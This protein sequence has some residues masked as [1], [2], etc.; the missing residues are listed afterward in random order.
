MPVVWLLSALSWIA[1]RVCVPWVR[2]G[3]ACLC[4]CR[5]RSVHTLLCGGGGGVVVAHTGGMLAH[6]ACVIECR[7]LP[8]LASA[9]AEVMRLVQTCRAW[10]NC[11][12]HGVDICLSVSSHSC[13]LQP[14]HA[15]H[16]PLCAP[17]GQT[18]GDQQA[19]LS[20]KPLA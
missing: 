8:S 4:Q 9:G 16:Y 15:Y 10:F 17:W 3:F 2:I 20:V 18:A 13:V 12:R 7:R 1:I 11:L 5:L 19:W 6:T 14:K